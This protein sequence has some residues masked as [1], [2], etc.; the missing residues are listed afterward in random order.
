MKKHF[1]TF[2]SPGTFMAEE[3]TKEIKSWDVDKA[4][5]MSKAIK[6]RYNAIPYGFSFST[7]ERKE[8]DLDSKVTKTSGMYYINCEVQTLEDIIAKN[9]P[10]D[11]IL[12]QNMK[13]NGWDKIV[14]TVKGW[15]WSQPLRKGDV[16]VDKNLED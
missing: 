2:Y 3:T 5:R 1:V 7:R 8:K 4:V 12:I 11:K 15:Q 10:K 6:E 9:D 16:V 14:T 13:G